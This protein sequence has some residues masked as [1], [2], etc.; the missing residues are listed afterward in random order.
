[1]RNNADV[2]NGQIF[3]NVYTVGTTNG[4]YNNRYDILL[5]P[6]VSVDISTFTVTLPDGVIT[7]DVLAIA[8]STNSAA[9]TT[10]NI[11]LVSGEFVVDTD[12]YGWDLELLS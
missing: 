12:T 7:E 2:G 1:M 11:D 4:W 9:P 8:F 3:F 5:N 6:V 10:L